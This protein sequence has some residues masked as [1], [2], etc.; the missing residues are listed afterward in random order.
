VGETTSTQWSTGTLLPEKTYYWRVRAYRICGKYS[1]YPTAKYFYSQDTLAPRPNPSTW[2]TVPQPDGADSISMAATAATDRSTPIQYYFDEISENPGGSDSGW[3]PSSTYID[4]GLSVGIQYTYRVRTR[5]SILNTG[6]WSTSETA[7]PEGDTSPPVPNPLTWASVPVAGGIDNISMTATTATDACDV[8]YYFANVTDPCHD[9]GWQDE[10]TYDDTGLDDLTQY[11]YR[12]RARD[13]SPNQNTGNWS[14]TECDTTEDGTAPTPD[15]MTWETLPY[16]I[17]CDFIAMTATAASDANVVEYYFANVTDPC[18]DSGWQDD[19]TYIDPNL[20]EN[21]EYCYRVK[22]RDKSANQNETDW[23]TTSPCATTAECETIWQFAVLSDSQGSDNGVNTAM[24]SE[25]ATEIASQ[26]NVDLVLVAGDLVDGYTDQS[27]LE[28][29]FNTW[30]TTMEPI[31]TS[32][33]EVYP[34]RGNHDVGDPC[35]PCCCVA[36]WNNVFDLPDNGPTTPSDERNLTYSFEH[37]NAFFVGLDEFVTPH[38]VNQIWLNSELSAND[39]PHIFTFGHEP[40]FRAFDE[41]GRDALDSDPCSR[42]AFWTSLENTGSRVYFCGHDHFYNLAKTNN[43]SDP[44]DDVYQCIN[45]PAGGDIRIG[46]PGTYPGDHSDYAVENWE[47]HHAEARGYVLVTVNC[48]TVDVLWM[49]RVGT[50]VYQPKKTWRYTVSAGDDSVAPTPD[51]MTWETVPFSTESTS[52]SMTAT[53]ASDISGVEYYF[54]ETS[55]NSGG[56]DSVWQDSPIYEDIGLSELTEYIYRVKARDESCNWNETSWSSSEPVTTPADV[57]VPAP[58]PAIWG[59]EPNANDEHSISMAAST[60]SDPSGVEYYFAET[61]G[62]LGGADSGWQ[63]DVSYTDMGL[64]E[65]TEYTYQVMMQDQSVNKNA[66]LVSLAASATTYDYTAPRPDPSTWA[67]VPYATSATSISMRATPASDP[68]GVEYYFDCTGGGGND[69]SWRSNPTYEDTGL[70]PGTQYTYTVKV[71]DKSSPT[72][73]ERNE[74]GVSTAESATT[75]DGTPP[76]PNPA[77]WASMPS[78][79]D[80]HSVSMTATTGSDSSGVQYY[81]EETSSN[82]GGD[83][84]GWQPASSY[85]DIDLTEAT[86]YAYRVRMRDESV[87]LNTGAWSTSENV[88]TPDDTAPAPSP[89][90]WA[91]VPSASGI[92][93]V[94]M[95]VTSGSDPSGVEYYFANITDPCH[96]SDWQDETTYEDTGLDDLTQ[97]TYRVRARDKSLSQNATDWS[98]SESA[99]TL[100]GTAPTPNPMTWSTM[101]YVTG[102]TSISMTAATASDPSGVEY[103]FECTLGGGHHSAWQVSNT[104]EDTGLITGT[105]YKYRLKARDQSVNHN[106]TGWSQPNHRCLVLQYRG[107]Y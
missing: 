107:C 52:A 20:A 49:E 87:N 92:D 2:A 5:D 30:I 94:I 18:H 39:R 10:T 59:S 84:S 75:Q 26:P 44:N 19:T 81:F 64:L 76:A 106:E 27:T 41:P 9:S 102:S 48:G 37:R 45:G 103:R 46:W 72:P 93:S 24:L 1:S 105:T 73:E 88:T 3:Q 77:T 54:D 34:V 63:P 57:N 85:T 80:E 99:T 53:T 71:R 58:D 96:N 67:I 38:H 29:Q 95:T 7:T 40:A 21:T 6:N 51:P 31:Y 17:G 36:A 14:T 16:A 104:Y 50:E 66:G 62:N 47:Q 89:A 74:T 83:D 101:P 28:S 4:T 60:G 11:C 12:V 65:G 69:S 91:S 33:I 82:P 100:D 43:D 90:T 98:S 70:Q 23:S 32:D 97:Y 56:S 13:K 61:S 68:S 8:E 35:D 86:Q 22:A 55:D 42:D 78:A 79:D 25:L 15:P